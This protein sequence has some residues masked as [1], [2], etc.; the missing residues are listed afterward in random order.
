MPKIAKKSLTSSRAI[1]AHAFFHF[2]SNFLHGVSFLVFLLRRRESQMKM[3]A[4][5]QQVFIEN[6]P[7]DRVRSYVE[8]EAGSR[9]SC[10]L[11]RVVVARSANRISKCTLCTYAD[12]DGASTTRRRFK[13]RSRRQNLL[14]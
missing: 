10:I 13:I 1:A 2:S 3:R 5:D 8:V 9:T 12:D 14:K 6:E 4:H 11:M 7:R